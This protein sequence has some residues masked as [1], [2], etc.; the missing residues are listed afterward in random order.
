[1]GIKELDM[2][3]KHIQSC[4]CYKIDP[5]NAANPVS[6]ILSAIP[7]HIA[8]PAIRAESFMNVFLSGL[9][10]VLYSLYNRFTIF[11][12]FFL[13]LSSYPVSDFKQ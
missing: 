7:R 5:S 1:M 4:F 13:S 10:M 12:I 11:I 3:G 8:D 2:S 9:C 6:M